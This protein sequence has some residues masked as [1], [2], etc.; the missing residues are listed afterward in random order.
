M[1][2]NRVT[3]SFDVERVDGS[4]VMQHGETAF[5]NSIK[6]SLSGNAFSPGLCVTNVTM[7]HNTVIE[8]D[9]FDL[10]LSA[11]FIVPFGVSRK[12]AEGYVKSI[13]KHLETGVSSMNDIG[14]YSVRDG[15]SIDLRIVKR[16][17]E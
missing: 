2:K 12:Y 7:D 8:E 3:V 4:N 10:E 17:N 15:E 13:R 1:A 6:T 16:E 14:G 9:K 5:V 11:R